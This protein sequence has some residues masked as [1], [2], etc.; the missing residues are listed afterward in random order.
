MFAD[1][2]D[3]ATNSGKVVAMKEP[4]LLTFFGLATVYFGGKALQIVPTCFKLLTAL[5]TGVVKWPGPRIHDSDHS[6]SIVR[7]RL[8]VGYQNLFPTFISNTLGVMGAFVFSLLTFL[9]ST[10]LMSGYVRI[11]WTWA[12]VIMTLF[13]LAGGRFCF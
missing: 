10:S 3:V 11:N 8:G 4:L 6:A 9:S 1:D 5:F 7:E 13:A 12:V 2:R